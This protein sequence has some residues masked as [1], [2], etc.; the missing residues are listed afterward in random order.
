VTNDDLNKKISAEVIISLSNKG[1][2]HDLRQ[3]A[4]GLKPDLMKK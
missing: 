2:F 3:A 1:A 4:L